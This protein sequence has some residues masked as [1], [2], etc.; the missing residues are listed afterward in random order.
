MRVAPYRGLGGFADDDL[1]D[2][3]PVADAAKRMNVTPEQVVELVRT[4]AL[5]Y[6]GGFG[7][8]LVQP[9]LLV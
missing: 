2:Y 8:L 4:G 7:Q 9:A 6:S 3:V 5:R 1:F